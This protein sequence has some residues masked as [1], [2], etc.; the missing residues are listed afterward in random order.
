VLERFRDRPPFGLVVA[1]TLLMAVVASSA[2]AGT[3]SLTNK[4]TKAKVKRIAEREIKKAAPSLS[5]AHASTAGTATSAAT[6]TIAD[7]AVH[8]TSAGHATT[9]DSTADAQALGGYAA[10]SL[11]RT[12]GASTAD[13][14]DTNG[15]A[16]T[17]TI[18]APAPGFVTIFATADFV[19][20]GGG[21]DQV[22]CRLEIDEAADSTTPRITNVAGGASVDSDCATNLTK[23]VSAG[24]HKIDLEILQLSDT[25][26]AAAGLSVIYT[27]FGST[28]ASP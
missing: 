23:N 5:V 11:V 16:L 4:I 18:A 9:A 27:P 10:G 2:M 19:Y 25:T 3:A 13:A 21:T 8:A 26:V 28:G 7:N 1:V 17:T 24:A 14:P 20:G 6:A 22:E 15:T 12:A